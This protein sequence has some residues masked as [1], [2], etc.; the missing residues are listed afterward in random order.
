MTQEFQ[1]RL[2]SPQKMLSLEEQFTLG[3]YVP[4]KT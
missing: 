3:K 4:S 2:R 1:Y